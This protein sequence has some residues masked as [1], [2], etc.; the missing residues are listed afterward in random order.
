PA[1]PHHPPPPTSAPLPRPGPETRAAPHPRPPVLLVTVLS[2]H[3]YCTV[4]ESS[5]RALARGYGSSPSTAA[6]PEDG[7]ASEGHHG[8]MRASSG[9]REDNP[10][11]VVGVALSAI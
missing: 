11:L 3:K 7:H 6:I 4:Q 10:R 2:Y 9:E 1:S 5:E 8:T